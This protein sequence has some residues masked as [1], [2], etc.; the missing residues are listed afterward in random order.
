[1]RRTFNW[2]LAA[3]LVIAIGL[4]TFGVYHLWR[5]QKHR[6][7]VYQ[8]EQGNLAYSQYDWGSAASHYGRYLDLVR[9][10]A[11]LYENDKRLEPPID[12]TLRQA[13]AILNLRPL[14]RSY[15]ERVTAIYRSVLRMDPNN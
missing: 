6:T 13:R 9:D 3:V 2:R 7:A 12:I 10:D 14:K 4:F 8:L 11:D 15:V 5:W 1:M